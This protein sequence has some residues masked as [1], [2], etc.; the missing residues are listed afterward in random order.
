MVF[1][2]IDRGVEL[3]PA[4]MCVEAN[5][6]AQAALLSDRTVEDDLC[7]QRATVNDLA[8]IGARAGSAGF[9]MEWVDVPGFFFDGSV[10]VEFEPI[11]R[12]G[13]AVVAGVFVDHRRQIATWCEADLQLCVG[14]HDFAVFGEPNFI[15]WVSRSSDAVGWAA[16][17][18]EIPAGILGHLGALERCRIQ[19]LGLS[20]L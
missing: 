5:R 7:A 12:L 3:D 8:P 14:E 20:C 2:P 6:L 1:L 17:E 15:F 10:V 16:S 19:R 13:E 9:E 18:D 4:A 11:A